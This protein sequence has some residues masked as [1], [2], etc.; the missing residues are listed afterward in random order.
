[1]SRCAKKA[2]FLISI[3]VVLAGCSANHEGLAQKNEAVD[4]SRSAWITYW[5]LSSGEKELARLGKRVG[6]LVYFAAYFDEMDRLFAPQ[7]LQ[8]VKNEH[9]RRKYHAESYLC[10]VNDKKNL[11][12]AVVLKDTDLLKRVLATDDLIDKHV[13]DIIEITQKAQYDGIEIDY[14]RVWKDEVVGRQFVKFIN[15]IAVK[16]RE[17]NL[18]LRIV[19]EPNS[20]FDSK[21]F[22]KGPEYVVMFYN[23]Y[24]THSGPGPKANKEFINKLLE[25]IAELPGEKTAAFA[26]GGCIW[27]SDGKKQYITE[28]EAVTYARAY[29]ASPNRDAASQ[30]LYFQYE[31]DNV[32]YQ[33]WY[34]DAVTLNYWR[35]LA[36]AKEIT[37]I[38]LWRLGGNPEIE[39]IR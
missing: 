17:N 34:A 16:A 29:D 23:L 6:K 11:S 25:R 38:A 3:L 36:K 5:D 15:K 4:M 14:E 1:M 27:G 39:K 24:G 32:T 9:L 21:Q 30:S 35:S 13:A 26:L 37:N 8:D 19:L 2:I 18:K 28:Q 12:G 31:N 22:V 10:F 33:I 7:Q 20:P